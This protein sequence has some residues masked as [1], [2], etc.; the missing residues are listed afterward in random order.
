M[1]KE[2]VPMPQ[3][4]ISEGQGKDQGEDQGEDLGKDQGAC[5]IRRY[6]GD[7]GSIKGRIKKHGIKEISGGQGEE[8]KEH[9]I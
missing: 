2:S 1:I 4:T 3:I 5:N 6:R 9:G 7:K 8:I